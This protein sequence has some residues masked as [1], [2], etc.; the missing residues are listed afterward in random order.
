M[1]KIVDSLLLIFGITWVST[2]VHPETINK[3]FLVETLRYVYDMGCRIIY[4]AHKATMEELIE[5]VES[6][7]DDADDWAHVRNDGSRKRQLLKN[8]KESNQSTENSKASPQKCRQIY[9]DGHDFCYNDDD[10]LK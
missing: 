9:E 3:L 1:L 6:S 5:Y 10:F 8:R 2:K 7:D 4:V